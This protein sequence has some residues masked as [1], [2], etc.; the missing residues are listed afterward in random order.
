MGG[1]PFSVVEAER[2]APFLISKQCCDRRG[3]CR[4]I[5]S[6]YDKVAIVLANDTLYVSDIYRG[7]GPA[8]RHRLEQSVW[9]L[10][11]I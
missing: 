7:N 11:G 5:I 2:A 3:K 8:R 1:N 9:H 6:G 4:G 10:L